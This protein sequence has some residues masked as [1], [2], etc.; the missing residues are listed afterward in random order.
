LDLLQTACKAVFALAAGSLELKQRF[1]GI[2]PILH[3]AL[4]SREVSDAIKT[5]IKEA[6]LKVQ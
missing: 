3:A 2:Q 1:Q 6:F 5:D 4:N